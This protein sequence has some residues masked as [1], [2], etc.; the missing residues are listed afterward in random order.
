MPAFNPDPSSNYIYPKI[1]DLESPQI[2][3]DPVKDNV[4]VIQSD[5]GFRLSIAADRALLALTLTMTTVVAVTLTATIV[6][7]ST[8]AMIALIISSIALGLLFISHAYPLI[9]PYLPTILGRIADNIRAIVVDFFAAFTLGCFMVQD[10]E[11]KNPK[12]VLA[13]GQQPILLVHG[14]LGHSSNWTYIRYR[15][16]KAGLGPIFTINLG[17]VFQ[18]ID[19]DYAQKVKQKAEE[20]AK[21]TGMTKL[22]IIGHSMGGIVGSY[23]ATHLAPKGSVT[24][25]ITL[26]SPLKG[27]KFSAV[28]VGE[29]AQQ[30][31]YRS[32]FIKGLL[33]K[34]YNSEDTRYYNF[35]SD[36]DEIVLPNSAA[37]LD[38]SKM[39][40]PLK[41]HTFSD[42]GHVSYPL[43]DRIVDKMVKYIKKNQCSSQL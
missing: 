13:D 30:M 40:A 1:R 25:I 42:L 32:D 2:K 24:D 12:N 39:K 20:I 31:N 5:Q 26:G 14:Y 7:A 10:L 3:I 17:S 28:E 34:I 4:S 37:L 23:Y 43:S 29:C 27:T 9:R 6:L 8:I 38:K 11:K 21:I 36:A 35:A 16:Q 18:S 19:G 22:I 41:T 15:L 33:E